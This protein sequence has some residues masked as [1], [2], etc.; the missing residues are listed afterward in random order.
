MP[1]AFTKQDRPRCIWAWASVCDSKDIKEIKDIGGLLK[2]IKAIVHQFETHIS[3][4]EALDE[5]KKNYYHYYQRPR[6]SNTQLVKNLQDMVDIIE[7]HGGS[8]TDDQALVEYERS[9]E[10]HLPVNERSPDEALK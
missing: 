10:S 8:A 4:Y 9:L 7:Y 3:I 2:Q 6:I 1:W 5:A